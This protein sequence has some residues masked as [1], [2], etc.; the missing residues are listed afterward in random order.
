MAER[1]LGAGISYILII[2]VTVHKRAHAFFRDL[3]V[4]GCQ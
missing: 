3:K 1:F 4:D 2:C